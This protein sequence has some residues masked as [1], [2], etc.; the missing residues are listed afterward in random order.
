MAIA[1]MKTMYLTRLDREPIQR[2][3][4]KLCA[5]QRGLFPHLIQQ[6]YR[7]PDQTTL[8]FDGPT[9]FAVKHTTAVC[10]ASIRNTYFPSFSEQNWFHLVQQR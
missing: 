9:K 10:C 2:L 5:Q 3:F 4:H 8:G 6:K 1:P 7:R